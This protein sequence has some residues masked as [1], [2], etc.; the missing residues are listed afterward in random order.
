MKKKLVVLG[1][2]LAMVL[3]FTACSGND[4]KDASATPAA[5]AAGEAT[6]APEETTAAEETVAPEETTAGEATVAPEETTAAE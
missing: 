3:S 4:K 5:S 6:V 2:A 1:L